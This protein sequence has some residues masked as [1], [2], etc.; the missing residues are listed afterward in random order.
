M[1][2]AISYILTL[3]LLLTLGLT[4][5]GQPSSAATSTTI[6]VIIDGSEMK[7]PDTR[8]YLDKNKRVQVPVR[9]VSE[10]LGATVTW[11]KSNKSVVVEKEENTVILYLDK[12]DYTINGI[13][14]TMDTIVTR[15]NG[16]IIVP[17][18]FVSEALGAVVTWDRTTHT[19]N[20]TTETEDTRKTETLDIGFVVPV[21]GETNLICDGTRNQ[22][23]DAAFLVDLLR[24]DV[25]G[26]IRDLESILLQK[27]DKSSVDEVIAHV[28]LKKSRWQVV[29]SKLVFDNKSGRNLYIEESTTEEVI[30]VFCP[31]K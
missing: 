29:P 16:R 3:A 13:E 18:R 21:F 6:K 1:K 19:V 4:M 2:K 20:I 28:K 7:F 15:K 10:A 12:K 25:P 5:G 11:V 24:K 14:K 22:V 17:I 8:P 26:Q 31:K 9:A 27:C 23:Q 30:I